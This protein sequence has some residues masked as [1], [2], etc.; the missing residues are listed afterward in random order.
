MQLTFSFTLISKTGGLPNI[1]FV[2]RKPKPLGTEFKCIGDGVTG[3]LTGLEICEGREAMQAKEGAKE[4]GVS[5]ACTKRLMNL[6]IKHVGSASNSFFMGD[7]WFG[8]VKIA[9]EIAKQDQNCCFNVKTS[10]KHS[11]KKWLDE[12][13]KDYPGGTWVTLKGTFNDTS[14]YFIGYK[15][16]KRKVL[17]FVFTPGAGTIQ[18]SD[19]PYEARYPDNY[20]NLHV[21]K[22][23]RPDVLSTYFSYCNAIDVHNQSRQ[24]DLALEECWVTGDPYFRLCTTMIGITVTDSWKLM[25][26]HSKKWNDE[27][28]VSFANRL[29]F[30][31]LFETD[32]NI[33]PLDELMITESMATAKSSIT[34]PEDS[35]QKKDASVPNFTH[36]MVKLPLMKTE[37]K[38][39]T[40]SGSVGSSSYTK[41]IRCV[42]CSRVE[43]V[44]RKTVIKCK[45]CGVGFCNVKTGRQCWMNHVKNGGPPDGK[46][47]KICGECML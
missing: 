11:P 46:K 43:G 24:H 31:I 8:S 47:R 30:N 29:C 42:W 26:Y 17:T 10:T 22:V 23:P 32:K 37:P 1:S 35:P 4:L 20:G 39:H 14:L 2:A 18:K 6:T 12:T 7:S 21:R 38:L 40:R 33:Q 27:R 45:E 9:A 3:I 34:A 41:Q 25:K 28:I 5:A 44:M 36:T 15:Y 19:K 13:M 16:N